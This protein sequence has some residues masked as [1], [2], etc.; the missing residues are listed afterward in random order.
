M[1]L[2]RT[3]R[4]S[5]FFS[6]IK[7]PLDKINDNDTLSSFDTWSPTIELH[8]QIHPHHPNRF[9]N[10]LVL[11]N[12][13][14]PELM[15]KW[16]E[17]ED[18]LSFE[19][20]PNSGKFIRVSSN[21]TPSPSV[22]FGNNPSTLKCREA[23]PPNEVKQIEKIVQGTTNYLFQHIDTAIQE[24]ISELKKY[25][26]ERDSS[27]QEAKR[28]RLSPE[29]Q[30]ESERMDAD[31]VD[32]T[33]DNAVFKLPFGDSWYNRSDSIVTQASRKNHPYSHH[34]DSLPFKHD[35][36]D[37][38]HHNKY[39][40][41]LLRVSTCCFSDVDEKLI[42]LKHGIPKSGASGEDE[43]C[44]YWGYFSRKNGGEQTFVRNNSTK[45]IAIGGSSHL[46]LQL[47][48][49]QGSLHHFLDPIRKDCV[50]FVHSCRHL[51]TFNLKARTDNQTIQELYIGA[52][53]TEIPNS[54]HEIKR[55]YSM[56]KNTLII[57]S[58]QQDLE[59]DGNETSVAGQKVI[60]SAYYQNGELVENE[61]RNRCCIVGLGSSVKGYHASVGPE[62]VEDLA[63][64]RTTM[65]IQNHV[66]KDSVTDVLV[67]YPVVSTKNG[68]FRIASG[69]ILSRNEIEALTGIMSTNNK[70][71]IYAPHR[72]DCLVLRDF[73]KNGPS[74]V[75]NIRAAMNGGKLSTLVIRGVGGVPTESGTNPVGTTDKRAS[76]L[77]PTHSI[78]ISQ[79]L[80]CDFV[81]SMLDAFGRN[82]TINIFFHFGQD[83]FVYVGLFKI[84][85]V[86]FKAISKEELLKIGKELED[87]LKGW[88]EEC[89]KE[90]QK[91]SE[92]MKNKMTLSSEEK[93][94]LLSMCTRGCFVRLIPIDEN[95]P[96]IDP[97]DL[98]WNLVRVDETDLQT[99]LLAIPREM[100]TTMWNLGKDMNLYS[101]DSFLRQVNAQSSFAYINESGKKDFPA[102]FQHDIHKGGDGTSLPDALGCIE[103]LFNASV[104]AAFFTCERACD[105]N[106]LQEGT[107]IVPARSFLDSIEEDSQKKKLRKASKP[108]LTRPVHPT[109]L[110]PTDPVVLMSQMST[111]SYD[112][113]KGK[114][115]R[116]AVYLT[117]EATTTDAW[118]TIFQCIIASVFNPSSL[119]ELTGGE[120]IPTPRE[121]ENFISTLERYQWSSRLI[122]PI[123]RHQP[124]RQIKDVVAFIRFL[125]SIKVRLFVPNPNEQVSNLTRSSTLQRAIVILER[126][127]NLIIKPFQMH[128]IMRT[129][130]CCIELPFG[131]IDKVFFGYGSESAVRCF[132]PA[133][134]QQ[135]QAC[136]DNRMHHD[137]DN[138]DLVEV[139]EWILKSLNEKV[140]KAMDDKDLYIANEL[141]V[142]Q[143]EWEEQ[144]C[145][146]VHPNGR[147][148]DINDI[149]HAL[150]FYYTL[151]QH[152][153]PSRNISFSANIDGEKYLPIRFL[154]SDGKSAADLP[155]MDDFKAKQQAI[156]DAYKRLITDETYKNKTL[157]TLFKIDIDDDELEEEGIVQMLA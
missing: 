8:M 96:R 61:M 114:G 53:V 88:L 41:D 91:Y 72:M 144:E 55:V 50:R 81:F 145:H 26:L 42:Y 17:L 14:S 9:V 16:G 54:C 44:R 74:L 64:E 99:P 3:S 135:I 49:S 97:D 108:L 15:R 7:I 19:M 125:L 146:L 28:R 4:L 57:P 80:T 109:S 5:S 116:G 149:E 118:E 13:F 36:C 138:G 1:L 128:V 94:R 30:R 126:E 134:R 56:S 21:I 2:T 63:K 78:P 18:E 140:R 35:L 77:A 156:R 100:A 157:S 23:L 132:F 87:K 154:S 141:K 115:G 24:V 22:T 60:G 122:H 101:F 82:Q 119:L 20:Q 58:S 68:F 104:H 66:H 137:H 48:G 40:G 129:I 27:R 29:T 153:L 103:T 121:A 120:L 152:T 131:P 90:P 111:M 43:F 127:A 130:E 73:A 85:V 52:N 33:H 10:V 75:E 11:E 136:D 105:G 70:K 38:S 84:E 92:I 106:C 6:V 133:F 89:N 65:V 142:L 110:N 147:K 102:I 62:V 139:V 71:G 51:K 34:S 67:G 32:D 148:F 31:D 151:H 98:T 150:C 12:L 143:L 37:N 83:T 45:G 112:K 46:H 123:F 47:S 93:R 79:Q 107:R 124:F 113:I 39:H 117:D 86:E 59:A 155:L 76:R 69:R 25:L 95:Q